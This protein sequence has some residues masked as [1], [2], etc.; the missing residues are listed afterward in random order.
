LGEWGVRGFELRERNIFDEGSNSPISK[1]K[2]DGILT[3]TLKIMLL[4]DNSMELS[5]T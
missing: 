1:N 5:P 2:T 4:T 3:S